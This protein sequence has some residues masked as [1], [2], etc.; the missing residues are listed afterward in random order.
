MAIFIIGLMAP[1][2]GVNVNAMVYWM[3]RKKS[4]RPIYENLLY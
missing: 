3:P 1:H 4:D 2:N